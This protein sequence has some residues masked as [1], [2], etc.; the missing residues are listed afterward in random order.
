[1][2]PVVGGWRFDRGQ[3]G[4][5]VAQ[6]THRRMARQRHDLRVVKGAHPGPGDLDGMVFAQLA[7]RERRPSCRQRL[8]PAGRNDHAPGP[9]RR[10]PEAQTGPL[11]GRHDARTGPRLGGQRLRD[12]RHQTRRRGM[13]DPGKLGAAR[14]ERLEPIQR[15]HRHAPILPTGYDSRPVRGR[16]VSHAAYEEDEPE[17]A[18]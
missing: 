12:H 15:S 4:E 5:R 2:G 13:H 11:L 7:R 6:L 14:L 8:Q 18:S 9:I 17:R 3:R 1:V 16:N 10:Q